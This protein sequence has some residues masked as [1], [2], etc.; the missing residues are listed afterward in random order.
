MLEKDYYRRISKKLD[1]CMAAKQI[2]NK[3]LEEICRKNGDEISETSIQRI[4]KFH[5]QSKIN[6]ISIYHIF[7]ICKA[8]GIEESSLL[9]PNPS[10]LADNNIGEFG[11]FISQVSNRVFKGYM[12][13]FNAYFYPTKGDEA[14]ILRGELYLSESL[15]GQCQAKFKIFTKRF[16]SDLKD[17][18]IKEY[19]GNMVISLNMSACYLILRSEKNGEISFMTFRYMHM[20][21]YELACRIA[22]ALTT[23]AGENRRPTAHRML[24]TR[25][26]LSEKELDFLRS[27]LL[28]NTEKIVIDRGELNQI[29]EEFDCKHEEK[30]RFLSAIRPNHYCVFDESLFNEMFFDDVKKKELICKVRNA[31]LS[32]RYNKISDKADGMLYSFLC[33]QV[34]EG[35]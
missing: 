18:I 30:Q 15:S 2:S 25:K 27:Q 34:E 11:N 20:N 26:E 6:T 13:K 29:I 14:E 32:A 3:T 28:M 24:L 22:L 1:G 31:S 4:R 10:F 19:E 17:E 5:E 35:E 9:D 12:G 23:S 8:L 7:V 33:D 21:E 16:L